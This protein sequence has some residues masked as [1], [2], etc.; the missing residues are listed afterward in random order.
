MN[1]K[2]N[3]RDNSTGFQMAPM[4]DILFLLL[5]FFITASIYAQWESKVEIK[6]PTAQTG[7]FLPRF[8]GEIIINIDKDGRIQVNMLEYSYERMRELLAELAKTYPEQPVI[9]RADIKTPYEYIIKTLDICRTADI[10]N[11]SFA[12]ATIDKATAKQEEIK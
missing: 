4:V 12:T 2:K 11:I 7:E 3:I 1:F 9:I 8:P 10:T 6:V 5:I